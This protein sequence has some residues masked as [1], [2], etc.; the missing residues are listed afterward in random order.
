MKISYTTLSV[1]E[2]TLEQA[3][4]LASG[5]RLD[6]IELRGKESVHISP[7]NSFE[8]VEKARRLIRQ[9]GLSIPCLTAYTKFYQPDEISA[10]AQAEELMKMVHLAEYLGAATVRT[11]MGDIPAGMDRERA[12]EIGRAGL[13]HVARLMG[14]SPVRVVIETHDSVKDGASL[15]RLLDGVPRQIGVLLDIIHPWDMGESI[16]ETWKHIGE[17]IYHV[18]LKD[19]TGTVPGGRVYCALGSGL[20]DVEK[21]AAYLLK[22]GYDGFFSLEWER[23]A[24]GYEGITLEMQM[25]SLLELEEQLEIGGI[26]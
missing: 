21:K 1:P 8:Y 25:E 4:A 2:K 15:A 14:N 10:I 17:R 3:V 20:L 22:Q 18:H 12:D 23:S 13:N 9:A 24:E 16:E 11:F 5:W 6:G 7:E 19:I 26:R